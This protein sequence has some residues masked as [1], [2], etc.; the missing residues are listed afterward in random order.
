MALQHIINVF[1][2]T[3]TLQKLIQLNLLRDRSFSLHGKLNFTLLK[4]RVEERS[5]A[6]FTMSFCQLI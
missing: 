3:L 5:S 1:S 6:A 2:S 4:G